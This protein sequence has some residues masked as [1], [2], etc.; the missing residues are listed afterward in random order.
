MKIET[1]ETYYRKNGRGK[2]KGRLVLQ[3]S[4]TS[5]FWRRPNGT[6]I[7]K[8]QRNAFE[9]WLHH[10]RSMYQDQR[11]QKNID[12]NYVIAGVLSKVVLRFLREAGVKHK[13]HKKNVWI[14][15]DHYGRAKPILFAG[16]YGAKPG[17]LRKIVEE[18]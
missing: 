11:K 15:K 8:M 14:F 13:H 18:A 3:V 2:L 10:G 12:D 4:G 9:Y 17:M 1:N 6:R 5:V 7:Y 16:I